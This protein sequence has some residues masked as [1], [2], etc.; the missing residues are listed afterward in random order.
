MT[1]AMA[2]AILVNRDGAVLSPI[3]FSGRFCSLL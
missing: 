3:W 1:I 2:I